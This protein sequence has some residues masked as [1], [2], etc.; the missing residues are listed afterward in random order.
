L[1]E[2]EMARRG[3]KLPGWAGPGIS[4]LPKCHHQQVPTEDNEG[5]EEALARASSAAAGL[6]VVQTFAHAFRK[7]WHDKCGKDKGPS[8]TEE[9]RCRALASMQR[10]EF[11]ENYLRPLEFEHGSPIRG[12]KLKTSEPSRL[13]A[14]RMGLIAYRRG[15]HGEIIP[16][17]VSAPARPC[18]KYQ[19]TRLWY[20]DY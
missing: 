17:E 10:K 6:H 11:E 2:Y 1:A 5:P 3:C 15:L 9:F 13:A 12:G 7:A 18:D 14:A 4:H 8:G 20:D 19:P 16:K